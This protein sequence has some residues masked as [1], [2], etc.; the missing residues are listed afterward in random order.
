MF[1]ERP[2]MR[3]TVDECPRSSVTLQQFAGR[4]MRPDNI[5]VKFYL[6]SRPHR[7]QLLKSHQLSKIVFRYPLPLCLTVT[8]ELSQY[9][10]TNRLLYVVV[11]ICLQVCHLHFFVTF[12]IK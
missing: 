2:R 6:E 9:F 11:H 7:P 3:Y 10:V 12:A 8:A 4:E 5:R 1:Y